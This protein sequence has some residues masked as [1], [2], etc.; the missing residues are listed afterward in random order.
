MAKESL[1][2]YLKSKML[3]LFYCRLFGATET[4]ARRTSFK[5]PLKSSLELALKQCKF[6][7]KIP[8]LKTYENFCYLKKWAI[9][10]MVLKYPPKKIVA[11]T[12]HVEIDKKKK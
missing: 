7:P 6:S 4:K 3:F 5:P 11:K 2:L 12:Y 10:A 8:E 1:K 9:L